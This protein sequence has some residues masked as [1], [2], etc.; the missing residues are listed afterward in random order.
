MIR[1]ILAAET[2]KEYMNMRFSWSSDKSMKNE[3][4]YQFNSYD[5]C[6]AQSDEDTHESIP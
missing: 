2:R 3:R 6:H 4:S 1:Y 5:I